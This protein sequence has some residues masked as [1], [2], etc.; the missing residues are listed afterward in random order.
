MTLTSDPVTL[1]FDL[2]HWY[3]IACEVMKTL[4]QI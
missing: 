1:T 4:Y 2:Y 3:C